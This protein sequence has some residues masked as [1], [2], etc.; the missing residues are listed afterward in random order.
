MVELAVAAA[1][2]DRSVGGELLLAVGT[3]SHD[4][5]MAQAN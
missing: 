4:I 2:A 1:A 5:K 3:S